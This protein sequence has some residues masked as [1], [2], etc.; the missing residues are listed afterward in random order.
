MSTSKVDTSGV[1]QP[2]A[3]HTHPT[4]LLLAAEQVFFRKNGIEFMSP[5]PIPSWTEM[6]VDLRCPLQ[7]E[8]VQGTGVVVDCTGNRHAGYV[9]SLVFMGLTPQSQRRLNRLATQL[10]A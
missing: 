2:V 7:R 3:V 1:F 6:T 10:G 8:S 5:D 4:K 9:V